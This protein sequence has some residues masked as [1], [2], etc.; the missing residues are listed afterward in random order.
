MAVERDFA[1]VVDRD[2]VHLTRT[3]SVVARTA[4][5]IS[6]LNSAMLVTISASDSTDRTNADVIL[7]YKKPMLERGPNVSMPIW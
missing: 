3:G 6:S 2:Q 1:F 7:T 4:G 5:A